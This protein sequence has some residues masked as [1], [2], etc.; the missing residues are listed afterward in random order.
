M[1]AVPLNRY[2]VFFSIAIAGCAVDL[3]TKNWIFN[4]LGMSEGQIEWVWKGVLGLRTDVNR[5]ALFGMGQGLTP[6]FAALS[7]AAVLGILFWLFYA[8]AARDWLLSIA[9][10]C[11]TAGILGNLYD[12]LGLH[13]EV[14]PYATQ[15]HKAGEPV[16]AVRDWI[17]V[18][19]GRYQWPAF[20]VADSLLVC[21]ALLLVWHA[22]GAKTNTPRQAPD[23]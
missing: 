13:G 18:M 19:I 20:N 15:F 3:A 4:R 23:V 21:G 5:G 16:R 11:V 1:K 12:R 22:F 14:W 17:V 9:L 2:I 7:A 6:L 10:G 8:G